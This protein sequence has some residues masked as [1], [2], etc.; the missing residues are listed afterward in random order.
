M[1][2]KIAKSKKHTKFWN[3]AIIDAEKMIDDEKKKIKELKSAI[4]T[5][6]N[7]RDNGDDFQFLDALCNDEG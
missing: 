2:E 7:F 4:I 6:K 3:Q 1:S 5:F